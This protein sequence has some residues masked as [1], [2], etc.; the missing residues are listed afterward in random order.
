MFTLN[1]LQV[2]G[3]L[4]R[5]QILAGKKKKKVIVIVKV[6]EQFQVTTWYLRVIIFIFK[7]L[8]FPSF[9]SLFL[10]IQ[11]IFMYATKLAFFF[12]L[13][14]FLCL[15]SSHRTHQFSIIIVFFYCFFSSFFF[16]SECLN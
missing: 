1:F 3:E 10:C 11:P 9:I 8:F 4:L 13:L 7:A 6:I 12:L 5:I 16:I 15:R 14:L 2:W